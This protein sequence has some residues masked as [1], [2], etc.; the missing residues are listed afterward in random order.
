[1]KKK[2]IIVRLREYILKFEREYMGRG[3]EDIKVYISDDLIIFR[4]KGILTVAETLLA[5]TMEGQLLIKQTR[6][7]LINS[8][9]KLIYDGIE[10]IVGIKVK[11]L[12]TDISIDANERIIILTMEGNVEKVIDK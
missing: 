10:K 2:E 5:K 6:D 4:L 9:K 12:Y 7:K 3:P 11:S 1:M 8:L